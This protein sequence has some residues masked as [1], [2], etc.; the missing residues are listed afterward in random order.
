MKKTLVICC[1]ATV[2]LVLAVAMVTTTG[3][4]A[5]DNKYVGIKKC[6]M[7]HA[8]AYKS[9]EETSHAKA[10]DSLSDADKKD[11]AKLKKS[12][13]AY[14]EPGGFKSVA[15]TPE[16]ANVTCEACHG[17]GG[18]HLAAPM[19]DKEAKKASIQT[20]AVK[21]VCIGCHSVHDK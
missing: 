6:K 1:V 2:G 20:P 5:D 12:T 4:A 3:L 19:K 16:L 17:P 18:N 14:G 15:D 10:F 13:V 8:K 9:W 7:C 11:E 21:N